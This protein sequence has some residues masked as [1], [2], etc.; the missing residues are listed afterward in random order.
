MSIGQR[1]KAL[2]EKHGLSQKELAAIAKV[3]VQAVSS[4]ENDIAIPRMGPIERMAIYFGLL[5]SDIIEDNPS[6]NAVYRAFVRL[7]PDDQARALDYIRLLS[8]AKKQSKP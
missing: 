8:A 7:D 5:K 6:D 4:W 1:I 3:S 2:R